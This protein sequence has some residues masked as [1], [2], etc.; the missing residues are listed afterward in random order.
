MTTPGPGSH[1]FLV[2]SSLQF[3]L[4][5]ALAADRQGRTGEPCRMVFVPDVLDPG[6]F[7][8][9]AGGWAESPFDR[10]DVVEARRARGTG[11]GRS[12]AALRRELRAAVAAAAPRSVWVFNDREE[13]GQTV[14][15]E[16]ARRF[17]HAER[18]CVEDGSIAYT[19]FTYRAHRLATR[20]RQRLRVGRGWHD[21]RVLGTHPLV[22]RFVAIHPA[23]LRPELRSRAVDPFPVEA[24]ELPALRSLARAIC[25]RAGFDPAAVPAGAVL[26]AANHSSYAE[27]NP[28]YRALVRACLAGLAAG[29]RRSFVKY[30]PREAAPDPFGVL[31]S[32]V[33]AEVPRTLPAECLYLGLR[34]RPLVV[35]AGMSTSLLTAALLMPQARCAALVHGSAAGDAWDARLLDALHITPLAAA[36]EVAHYLQGP[37]VDR[38]G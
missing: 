11:Q 18:L 37:G 8:R 26:L 24:L 33:A 12:S 35:V 21:V 16:T 36:S 32:G 27:R 22:Q 6:L 13:A 28:D 31:A 4:A 1:V 14:L 9:A 3:L 25:A 34:D 2:R 17:P 19:G 38:P 7:E 10:V 15:A 5:S 30:H 20:W 23:L 29:G